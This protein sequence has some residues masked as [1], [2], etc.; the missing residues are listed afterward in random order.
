MKK[1]QIAAQCYTLREYMHTSG[2]CD[3]TFAKLREI[4]YEAVQ[5]SGTSLDP[6]EIKK[7]ADKNGLTICATHDGGDALLYTPE[8]IIEKLALY[9]CKHTAYPCPMEYTVIDYESTLD[10][11]QA[12]EA[13]A[14]KFEAAGMHLSYHN[15]NTE[16]RKFNGE[17]ILDIIYNNAPHLL[18]EIDTYWVQMGGCNPVEYVQKYA[19]RQQ[20]FHL[21]DFGVIYPRTSIM[22]PVGSGNLDWNAIIP[23]AEAGTTEWFIVEQDQC[24]KDV[25][26]SL[27]DS[28]DYL[29]ANFVK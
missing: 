28:F 18:A 1:S 15:H 29:V 13:S 23:A 7:Y 8:V 22:V 20:I 11:A 10:F 17:T 3:R 9:E 14:Q 2:S 21:K 6:K 4:G 27:K 16:F 19:N 26:E 12:L 5:I 24:Q 25:F